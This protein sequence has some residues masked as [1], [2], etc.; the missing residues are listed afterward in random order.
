M[1]WYVFI[2]VM[3]VLNIAACVWG[4]AHT[5]ALVPLLGWSVSSLVFGSLAVVSL[6]RKDHYEQKAKRLARFGK[7][8]ERLHRKA[9]Q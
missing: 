9:E 6:L 3:T 5:G 8:V 4:Y 2:V 7:G 1:F